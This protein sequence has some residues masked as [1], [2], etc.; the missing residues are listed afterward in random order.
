MYVPLRTLTQ[1]SESSVH[2]TAQSL[3]H[4]HEMLMWGSQPRK[5]LDTDTISAVLL[6]AFT[7]MQQGGQWPVGSVVFSLLS[8]YRAL[9][10][11]TCW[12]QDA[13]VLVGAGSQVR[14]SLS[15]A[16]P[17]LLLS[18]PVHLVEALP[19]DVLV[20]ARCHVDSSAALPLGVVVEC[21]L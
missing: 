17:L 18:F 11:I 9:G 19:G 3:T 14:S 21:V 10:D 8:P 16:L 5:G 13:C 7:A 1:G 20:P 12:V 6:A 2:F 15:P 4:K